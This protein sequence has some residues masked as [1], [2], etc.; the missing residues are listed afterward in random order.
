MFDEQ[1]SNEFRLPAE[2]AALEGKLAGLTVAMARVDR[3]RLMFEAGRAAG[4]ATG[5]RR[6][7]LA[8]PVAPFGKWF[9][10]AATAAMTAATVL[11]GAM[12]VF[13][14]AWRGA[15][16]KPQTEIVVSTPDVPNGSPFAHADRHRFARNSAAW[17]PGNG[18]PTGYLGIRYVALAHGVDALERE[19]PHA[20]GDAGE[21]TSPANSRELLKELLPTAKRASI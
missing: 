13:S 16:G 12:L 5:S 21:V 7:A 9:W 20:G 1:E 2:L 8:E 6:S 17:M 19:I 4:S 3:D 18:T 10:P 11:L 15:G 14:G